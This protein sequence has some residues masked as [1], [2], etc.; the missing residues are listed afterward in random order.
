MAEWKRIEGKKSVSYKLTAYCG[1][2]SRG[3]QIRKFKTWKPDKG[4]SRNRMEKE[5]QYQ[6]E[7]FED[8]INK[9]IIAYDGRIKFEE[10]ASNWLENAQITPATRAGYN[11]Y[12]QR[13]NQ[14][15]GHIRLQDLQAHHLERFYKNLA[16]GG[17]NKRGRHAIANDLNGLL[18]TMKMPVE[19]LSTLAGISSTTIDTARKGKPISIDSANKISAALNMPVKQIFTVSVNTSGLSDKTILHHHRLISAILGKAKKE[20]IVPYNVAAEHANAPKVRK[21][22]AVYL[23]DKQAAL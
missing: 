5:A 9:G 20:R 19:K 1:Y 21:K 11:N 10:Y 15:I 12:I 17:I 4:I 8:E 2:D 22:E 16:E 14:A 18:K 6:A 13:I 3:K 7:K 23:D